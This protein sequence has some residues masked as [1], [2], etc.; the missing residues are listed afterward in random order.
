LRHAHLLKTLRRGLALGCEL[1]PP[2]GRGAIAAAGYH[3]RAC[4][5]RIREAEMQRCKTAHRQADHMRLVDLE[6]TDDRLDVLT[7]T[8][9]RI[10]LAVVGH[11]GGGITACIESD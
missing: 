4:A 11:L 6:S 7:R 8:L 5:V 1:C 3:Q 2:V 10:F 9:L